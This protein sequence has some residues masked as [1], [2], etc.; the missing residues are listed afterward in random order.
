MRVTMATA[1]PLLRIGRARATPGARAGQPGSD[2]HESMLTI[3]VTVK[4]FH[5]AGQAGPLDK[6]VPATNR[7]HRWRRREAARS[8]R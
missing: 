1:E 7:G 5:R 6:G 8:G 3:D 2:M 4:D